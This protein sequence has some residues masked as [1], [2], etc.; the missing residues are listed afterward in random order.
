MNG[1]DIGSVVFMIIR[2]VRMVIVCW[3]IVC[4]LDLLCVRLSQFGVE[5]G[6]V[7]C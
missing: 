6:C 2:M 5:V 4:S 7:L 1:V 3:C